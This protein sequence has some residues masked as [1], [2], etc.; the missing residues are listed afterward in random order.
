[1]KK[2]FAALGALSLALAFGVTAQ[3]QTITANPYGVDPEHY[4]C[5]SITQTTFAPRSVTLRDQFGFK[6]VRVVRPVLLCTPVSKNNGLLADRV[7][8]LVCYQIAN[9]L[10]ANKRVETT[11]QFGKLQFTVQTANLLCVPSLKRV[12]PAAQ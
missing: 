8:H 4:Q 5:Y 10:V 2:I 1:M 12:L 9:G 6:Q 7:S 11:N 3:A